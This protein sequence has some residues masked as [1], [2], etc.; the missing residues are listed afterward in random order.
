MWLTSPR[1][2]TYPLLN[3][4][5]L[6]IPDYKKVHVL[7]DS[8]FFKK[9]VP[10]ALY[11]G[12]RNLYVPRPFFMKNPCI[13]CRKCI[14]ICPAEALSPALGGSRKKIAIDYKKCIRCYCCNEVCPVKAIAVQ[15][16]LF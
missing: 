3:P 8:G 7:K 13:L 2:I 14:E 11:Q 10:P 12:I 1:E 15:R 5:N 6:V 16:R 9:A 4:E